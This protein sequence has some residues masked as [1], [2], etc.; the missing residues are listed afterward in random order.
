MQAGHLGGSAID[1]RFCCWAGNVLPLKQ[2]FRHESANGRTGTTPVMRRQRWARDWWLTVPGGV[3]AW[4]T[5]ETAGETARSPALHWENPVGRL[6][7]SVISV[8][9]S[10]LQRLEQQS[11]VN[12]L[13]RPASRPANRESFALPIRQAISHNK[14]THRR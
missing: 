2:H 11:P 4:F 13:G 12:L 1:Q 14:L 6:H 8:W 7:R 5:G 10:A 9:A 3:A